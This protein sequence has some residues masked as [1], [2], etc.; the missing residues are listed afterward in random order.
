MRIYPLFSSSK[1]NSTYIGTKEEGLL[2]DCG[3]SASKLMHSLE[4]AGIPLSAVKAVIITHEHSDHTK[5]LQIF[6]RK[7]G[8]PVY[9]T[10]ATLDSL[11]DKG[12]IS[13]EICEIENTV[14]IGSFKVS[15]YRTLHDAVCPCC[16]KIEY[17][18]S[19][20]AVCTDLGT[21][22]SDIENAL[23]G[24][25]AILLE[26]NYNSTMLKKG[27]YPLELK[28]RITSYDGHLENSQTA[29]F[30]VKLVRSGTNKLILGHLS[31]KNNT[32][33]LALEEVTDTLRKNGFERDRDYMIMAAGVEETRY[34]SV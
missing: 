20:C 15:T 32:P 10:A 28:K 1:G 2:V 5:G 6:T 21:V 14:D 11:C 18:G 29:D 3:V 4:N 25:D 17:K 30:A 27:P 22:T 26:A 13:S 34:F 7:T 8:I 16:C 19:S 12:S 23:C 31:E 24:V 33:E 9:S